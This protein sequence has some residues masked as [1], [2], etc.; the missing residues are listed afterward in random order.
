MRKKCGNYPLVDAKLDCK[1]SQLP[2]VS[3]WNFKN[4]ALM[5]Q[6]GNISAALVAD[7]GAPGTIPKGAMQ[8][9]PQILDL[10]NPNDRAS[11]AAPTMSYGFAASSLSS[12]S[13]Y[14][15]AP[16]PFSGGHAFAPLSVK[17][18]ATIALQYTLLLDTGA[19][20]ADR[21]GDTQPL[22]T[23]LWERMGR[24][25]LLDTPHQQRNHGNTSLTLWDTWQEHAWHQT[26]QS[27]FFEF[28]G[29]DG[30]CSSL[31]TGRVGFSQQVKGPAHDLW[32]NA[33][34]Q[35]LR[36]SLGMYLL[37]G[38]DFKIMSSYLLSNL[39]LWV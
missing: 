30:K 33:W 15:R 27:V 29:C 36:Q 37:R 1:R 20:D 34:F 16:A 39:C 24:E 11:P 5:V 35:T 28:E 18:N 32:M 22:A 12:H 31:A 17:R 7:L 9:H 19:R 6:R 26:A 4:P 10:F 2:Q 38:N 3:H 13:I 8:S 21:G 14:A 23:L 25:A